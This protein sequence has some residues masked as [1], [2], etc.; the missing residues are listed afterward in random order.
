MD[1][2]MTQRLVGQTGA[3][4]SSV[5]SS[6]LGGRWTGAVLGMG[7]LAIAAPAFAHHPLGGQLPSNF[8]E[9]FLSGVGHPILGP[10]HFAFVVALG[11]VTALLNQP[12][13]KLIWVPV[14]F[15]VVTLLGV[16]IHLMAW[17]VPAA[18][19]IVASTVILIGILMAFSHRVQAL[20]VLGFGAIAGLFHGYAYGEAIVGA[21]PSPLLAYLM[22]LT[23]IQVGI[24]VLAF[25][26]GK[27]VHS[28][29]SNHSVTIAR[30]AGLIFGVFGI[31][32]LGNTVG[33]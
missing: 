4:K 6:T 3:K 22:G 15:A 26:M 32:L 30:Y 14:S 29:F 18:E 7:S 25:G 8:I 12:W 13:R 33:A 24:V 5:S 1:H 23:I 16:G 20:A 21:E 2:Q 9:G 27:G 17:D 31:V 11:L 10:D 19:S 28:F